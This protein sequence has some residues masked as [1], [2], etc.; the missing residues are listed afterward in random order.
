MS[1]G[2]LPPSAT[3]TYEFVDSSVPPPFHRSFVLVFD[4]AQARIV[5]DS[6]GEVLADRTAPMRA[7][8]WNLVAEGFPG[9]RELVSTQP[10]DACTGGTGFA[11]TVVADGTVRFK[12]QGLACGGAN[13][14]AADRLA[15]WV[16][17]VRSL[18]P[19]MSELA[20]E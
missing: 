18:F 17:P 12:I 2:E 16:D 10:A 6:Y 3:V 20:P 1:E 15:G 7:D 19:T 14:A 11:A 5:V 4:R 9:I 13:T 8:A